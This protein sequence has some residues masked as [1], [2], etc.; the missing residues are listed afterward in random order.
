MGSVS[1]SFSRERLF[2]LVNFCC[3]VLFIIQVFLIVEGYVWPEVTNT[4][5]YHENLDDVDF[6]VKFKI[7]VQPGFDEQELIEAGYEDLTD[8]FHGRSRFNSSVFG[9]T[10]HGKSRENKTAEG[11]DK[12]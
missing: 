11:T 4:V 9:W 12:K 6:P 7:C 1:T 2:R 3:G 10:G 5:S 8:Y